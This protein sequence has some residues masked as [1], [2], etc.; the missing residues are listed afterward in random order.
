MTRGMQIDAPLVLAGGVTH[1]ILGA[2]SLIINGDITETGGANVL[3]A[4]FAPTLSLSGN[5]SFSGGVLGSLNTSGGTFELGSNTAAGAG[6]IRLGLNK[7]W[8]A[9]N[10]NRTMAN[11]LTTGNVS[12]DWSAQFEGGE[13]NFT[14][15]TALALGGSTGNTAKRFTFNVANTLTTIAGGIDV[16]SARADRRVGIIKDG[17]GTLVIGGT[18]KFDGDADYTEAITVKAG[19]LI[20]NGSVFS[21][22]GTSGQKGSIVQSTGILGG[23]G[24]LH[25]AAGQAVTVQSGGLLAPGHNGSGTF[26]INGNLTLDSGALFAFDDTGGTLDLVGTL[27]IDQSFGVASLRNTSGGSINWATIDQGTYT[28]MN[29]NFVFNENNINNFGQANPATD[30][31]TGKSA[32]FQQGSSPSSLQLVVV[33][34]P[35]TLG[36]TALGMGLADDARPDGAGDGACRRRVLASSS[37]L[38][39]AR[40]PRSTRIVPSG[41]VSPLALANA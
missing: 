17:V 27:S 34:E 33:P 5:N 23:I 20:L 26:T 9:I 14:S 4:S 37:R 22:D 15:A 18:S 28:L 6:E 2:N 36:L 41:F 7:I 19:A 40:V 32:Y 13:F 39:S 21:N 31:A 12:G 10:G 3:S 38:G 16:G 35:T 8:R 29:T 30:P 11:A 1:S 25:L 24:T